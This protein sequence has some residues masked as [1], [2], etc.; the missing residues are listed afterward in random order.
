MDFFI[1]RRIA[2]AI[3]NYTN[4]EHDMKPNGIRVI[5][6]QHELSLCN[7]TSRLE[8]RENSCNSWLKKYTYKIL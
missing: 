4:L 2:C 7:K 8:V 5:R 3:T 6:R 1:T